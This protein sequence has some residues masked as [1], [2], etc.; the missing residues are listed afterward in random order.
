[1]TR[2]APLNLKGLDPEILD[3]ARDVARRAGVPLESWI[4]SVVEPGGL[5]SGGLQSGGSPSEGKPQS[6][7]RRRHVQQVADAATRA[8]KADLGDHPIPAD[9]GVDNPVVLDPRPEEPAAAAA[10]RP[11]VRI[12][13]PVVRGTDPVTGGPDRQ[14][15]SA[16]R[17]P[18][19]PASSDDHVSRRV[20]EA[21]PSVDPFA[22]SIAQMLARLDAIDQKIDV[23]HEAAETAATQ[24]IADIEARLS[25]VL[26]NGAKPDGELTERLSLIE[27]RMS[28]IG[29]QIAQPR[30]IGRRGRPVAVEVADAVGEIRQRQRELEERSAASPDGKVQ[31]IVAGLQKEVADGMAAAYK[32]GPSSAI[33]QLQVETSRLRESIDGL[34][35][36]QDVNALEEAMLSLATGVRQAQKTA[37]LAAIARP[38]E[39]IRVQVSRLAEDVAENVHARVAGDVERLAAKVD[40]AL[41]IDATGSADRDALGRL[42]DE[43]DEIRRLIGAL[44]GPERIQSLA[45]GLQ[46]LSSQIAQLQ[47]DASEDASRMAELSPKVDGIEQ[48]IAAMG[49]KLD[50]LRNREATGSGSDAIIHRIDALADTIGRA[51]VSPVGDLIGRLEDLGETL[52][53]PTVPGGDLASIHA[54]LHDLAD[55]V[56]R[57]GGTGSSGEALDALAKQLLALS[58]RI[59]TRGTDPAIAG[60]ERAMND[61]LAQLST[62]G[63]GGEIG[64]LRLGLAELRAEQAA[65]EHRM[66]ATLNGVHTA[67]DKLTAHFGAGPS[68]GPAQP[69]AKPQI[70]PHAQVH[71]QVPPQS[72]IAAEPVPDPAV[73]G[74]VRQPAAGRRPEMPRAAAAAAAAPASSSDFSRI[75]DE[76]LEPGAGRPSRSRLGA[77]P[78]SLDAEAKG[79][80]NSEIKSNFI[81]AARRAALAAQA[82]AAETTPKGRLRDTLDG[83]RQ[84]APADATAG[85]DTPILGRV[86]QLRARIDK[87][88]RHLLLALAAV[89]LA[90]GSA[91]AIRLWAPANEPAKEARI[92]AEPAAPAPA[93]ARAGA[94]VAAPAG[95]STEVASAPAPVPSTAQ[96]AA[97]RLDPQTTQSIASAP[98]AAAETVQDRAKPTQPSGRGTVPRVATMSSLTADLA[99][100]PTGLAKLRQAAIEGEGAAIYDLASRQ[101]EGRGVPR[102]L[103]LAA[104]L[105]EKLATAG[106]APAQYKL[107]GQYEKGAGLT[108]DLAQAKAWYGRAAEQGNVRSMHNL[109]VIYAENPSASG[110]PDFTTAA[111][112]FR[113]GAEHGVRDSQYNLAV[114]Y[115]RGLGVPQDLV[116]SYLWFSA[117]AVQGD[118]DA[119]RKRDDVAGKL[120]AKDLVAARGLAGAFKPKAADP[121]TNEP[122]AASAAAAMTLLGAPAPM[123]VPVPKRG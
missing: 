56:D 46:A 111:Q 62:V 117:A 4:A 70:Q 94:D 123:P 68:S 85:S 73:A 36:G 33:S 39:M 31:G 74:A 7:R 100:I 60:L 114:L 28:E 34:A 103:S 75:R 96:Q 93:S 66:Q 49:E 102:D 5:Q 59:D 61:L 48:Q 78:D 109:A 6:R 52:R 40:R 16:S 122:P 69:P 101:A 14:V 119:A 43:L 63:D 20:G 77:T 95:A 21:A 54:M 88:R 47:G 23:K 19:S 84:T 30:P 9:S 116:Q 83:L 41:S 65:N 53:R 12:D 120:P 108:R 26:A 99:G 51:G 107:A 38:I 97:E 110:K 3:A 57:V 89:V 118:D 42:F 90:L 44:A 55:K 71:V 72:R 11:P 91:Q 27:R 2:N 82:E 64:S 10:E 24:T 76:I 45:H 105:F 22:A 18:V 25:T 35:T 50:A 1:M 81:A 86:A 121:A 106:Y 15:R 37:D 80:S 104:K 58:Q 115:A 87:R 113:R 67:L 8:P 79:P 17:E 29:E 32:Q 13:A 92:A 112:W 98:A